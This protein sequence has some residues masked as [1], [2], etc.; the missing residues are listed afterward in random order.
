M[1]ALTRLLLVSVLGLFA[2]TAAAQKV[3]LNPSDQ[4][5]NE[6]SGGG[7]ESTY[8]LINANKTADKLK[9]AGFTVKVD[10]DFLNA[11]SNAN[12]WGAD[13]FVS[14]HSNAGGAPNQGHGIE[15]LYVS[16]GGKVLATAVQNGLLG[17]VPY[18]DR[19]VIKRTNLHVLNATN[20]VATLA[21]VVFH[22]CSV[23]SGVKGHPPSE[24]A[25]LKSA[26]GQNKISSGLSQGV[27]TYFSKNCQATPPT[28]GTLKGVVFQDPDL[29]AHIAGATVSVAGKSVTYDGV[30]PWTFELDAGDYTVTASKAGF[31]PGSKKVTVV[32]NTT[33]WGSVGLVLENATTNGTIAGVVYENPE[34]SE[35]LAGAQVTLSTGVTLTYDGATD[36]S[37]VVPAGKY[38]LS[39]A[40]DG[41][42]TA[43][44]SVDVVKGQTVSANIGLDP[45]DGVDGGDT[46]DGDTGDGGDPGDEGDGDSGDPDDNGT[47]DSGSPGSG[48]KP[49]KKEGCSTAPG[50]LVA[51]SALQL[52]VTLWRRRRKSGG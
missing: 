26:D 52:A 28:K 32:A 21:E 12:S 11:P 29:N 33:V 1:R 9:A 3:Y 30:T 4:S 47:P 23:A 10:Q 16:T 8:A 37:F 40:L 17:N 46:G 7:V 25:F 27:C 15:S 6:V 35:H 45:L 22:D 41:Y 13:V 42:K 38:T 31:L 43:S 39:A 19:G 49:P 2:T 14:I 18:G 48:G 44:V 36:F 51:W 5:S 24:S 20:M 34:L 50:A